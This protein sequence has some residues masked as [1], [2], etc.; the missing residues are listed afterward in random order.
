[1]SGI[2]AGA[3][4]RRRKSFVGDRSVANAFRDIQFIHQ[5][6]LDDTGFNLKNLIAPSGVGSFQNPSPTALASLNL[7]TLTNA[8][9]LYNG[10]G[11]R[12]ALGINYSV[13]GTQIN[14][15][16]FTANDS[17]I[18]FGTIRGARIN[19]PEIVDG[20]QSE[21]SG[22][23]IPGSTTFNVGFDFPIESNSRL[24]P[25]VVHRNRVIQYLNSDIETPTATSDGDF[26]LTRASGSNYGT[27]IE[28]NDPG[29]T[30]P[31]GLPEFVSV[32]SRK[33]TVDRVRDSLRSELE[34]VN[35]D[36]L[37]MADYVA[38]LAGVPVSEI[39]GTASPTQTQ[40]KQYGDRVLELGRAKA[41]TA[42]AK[43][44]T[45]PASLTTTPTVLIMAVNRNDLPGYNAGTGAL[46]V[47][48]ELEGWYSISLNLVVDQ[49]ASTAQL[50]VNPRINTVAVDN[51]LSSTGSGGNR[52][53]VSHSGMFYLDAGDVFDFTATQTSGTATWVPGTASFSIKYE[54]I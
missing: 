20:I 1:M 34:K 39:I 29:V 44:P 15:N 48:S 19:G 42:Y 13:F 9:E 5:A 10:E 51:W 18:F 23:L 25:L 41:V 22:F 24:S 30:L 4:S 17:E 26:S 50:L 28:F 27:T 33:F 37:N 54:G 14:F 36:V 46:T 31:G 3:K 52:T 35:G 8:L 38:L 49:A 40:L 53:S 2:G 12:L 43:T 16:D 21:A 7:G 45:S 47:T 11:K 32:S 6:T